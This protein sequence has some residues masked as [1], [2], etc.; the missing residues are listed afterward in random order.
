[1]EKQ[2]TNPKKILVVDDERKNVTVLEAKLAPEGY[3]VETAFNGQEA[4]EKIRSKNPDLVLLDVAMPGMNGYQVCERIR[5]DPSIPYIPIILVTASLLRQCDVIHGLDVGADDYIRKPFDT[6]ELFSRVRAALRVKA[7]NDELSR[8]KAELSRYV[9]LS[10]LRVVENIASGKDTLSGRAADITVLFS[11]IR[12][13]TNIAEDMNP[14]EVFEMLNRYLSEQIQI[15][16]EHGGIVDKLNGDGVMAVFEGPEMAADAL[17]CAKAITQR[18][19]EVSRG[20]E[21]DGIGVGI[22]V[23]SG[24]VHVGSIGS[25]GRKDYTVVGNTVN[26]AARL[27]GCADRFQVLFTENTK[28]LIESEELNCMSMGKVTLKGMENPVNVFQLI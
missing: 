9:S 1:M 26:L 25:A 16:E 13:F 8:T 23:N 4:L 10:T 27:C 6:L 11:D 12:R 24:P 2:P 3:L 19:S 17:R 22:G 28:S 5:S 7:L 20:W 15:I 18:L 21:N 14:A